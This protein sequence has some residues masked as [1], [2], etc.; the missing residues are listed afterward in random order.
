MFPIGEASFEFSLTRIRVMDIKTRIDLEVVGRRRQGRPK[1]T[2]RKQVKEENKK[3]RQRRRG[4][5]QREVA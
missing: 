1:T 4:Q 3:I 2:W 5:R